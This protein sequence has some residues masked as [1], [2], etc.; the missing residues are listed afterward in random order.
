MKN[1]Y[2]FLLL[3]LFAIP[4]FA[5]GGDVVVTADLNEKRLSEYLKSYEVED[6]WSGIQ[7]V[8]PTELDL[9]G[10]ITRADLDVL[11]NIVTIKKVDAEHATFADNKVPSFAFC[12]DA[13][14]YQ[15]GIMSLEE[16]ILP[17]NIE[18]IEA[19]AFSSCVNLSKVNFNQLT[20]LKEIGMNAFFGCGLNDLFIPAQ[21]TNFTF[22]AFD[23]CEKLK[24]IQIDANNPKYESVD[25]AIYDRALKALVYFPMAAT[26]TSLVVKEGTDSIASNCF[27]R[28]TLLQEVTLPNTLTKVGFGLFENTQA[29]KSIT[30]P[31]G[32][33]SI[34]SMFGSSKIENVTFS[35]GLEEIGGNTFYNCENLK[36]ITLPK[37]VKNIGFMSF[38]QCPALESVN[39]HELVNLELIDDKAFENTPLIDLVDLS[40]ATKLKSIGMNAFQN[41]KEMHT[42][43]LP[44]G[45]EVIG[46]YAFYG[47][48]NLDLEKLPASLKTIGE[49]AFFNNLSLSSI[50]IGPNVSS[51]GNGAFS[52]CRN[53]AEVTVDENNV[54]YVQYEG[55]I[56]TSN[57]E[58]IVFIPVNTT[59]EELDL[60]NVAAIGDYVLAGNKSIKRVLVSN[61]LTTIGNSAFAD[62]EQLTTLNLSACTNLS[63]IGTKAFA[64]AS[65]LQT[66]VMPADDATKSLFIGESAFEGC[67]KLVSVVIPAQTS[68]MGLY[69]FRNCTALESVDFTKATKL[70]GFSDLFIG[71][72]ALKTL[73]L[74]DNI[75]RIGNNAFSGCFSLESFDFPNALSNNVSAT[76]FMNSGIKALNVK[77]THTKLKSVDGVVYSKDGT[78]LVIC[79]PSASGEFVV[80]EGVKRISAKAFA[81]NPAIT[82]IHLPLSL[83]KPQYMN[84]ED[85]F[86]EMHG[87]T[88]FVASDEHPNLS[89]IDGAIYSKDKKTLYAYPAGKQERVAN[90][91]PELESIGRTAFD[92]NKVIEEIVFPTNLKRIAM[93]FIKATGLRKI[94]LPAGLLS[95]S[96]SFEGSENLSEVICHAVTPPSI[97]PYVFKSTKVTTIFVPQEAVETYK[98]NRYWG[99]YTILPT[100]SVSADKVEISDL[101]ISCVEG[102]LSVHSAEEIQSIAVFNMAGQLIKRSQHTTF[103]VNGAK[104]VVA[105]AVTLTNGKVLTQ[106]VIVK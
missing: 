15:V 88:S 18:T 94:E 35:E 69:T 31:G 57:G 21:C 13:F 44:E 12:I 40:A 96:S 81:G 85:S 25:N 17:T 42:L 82:K 87:L 30:L 48:E 3:A 14:M 91:A 70:T 61:M 58:T 27:N 103:S 16:V 89:I 84:V 97:D 41:V 4:S 29:L 20:S 9:S 53:V 76:M 19:L 5:Q 71:C 102:T 55:M 49:N 86:Y 33:K 83:E 80:P 72:A 34:A 101:R 68:S 6:P 77:D 7:Y 23:F 104:G 28:N 60:T 39:F 46:G 1:F 90:L 8:G 74:H 45:L 56:V 2:I 38:S 22:S 36:S 105:V 59:I 67:E 43:K 95:L 26:N 63:S 10:L 37:T 62:M 11:F 50:A 52:N 92:N 99:V 100:G 65:N 98:A 64:G 93:S 106:K 66:L 51:I 32:I 47:C 24:T 73:I 79:P 75:N 78:Q 54:D